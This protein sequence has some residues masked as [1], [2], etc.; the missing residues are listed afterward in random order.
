MADARDRKQDD[1][2]TALVNRVNGL[3]DQVNEALRL[4]STPGP[5]GETG[6]QGP[7]GP[8]GPAGPQGPKGDPGGTTTQPPPTQPPPTQP[9][10][11]GTAKPDLFN[12]DQIRD[13]PGN[14]SAPG[15]ISEVADPLGS[16]QTVFKM[17]VKDSDRVISENPRAQLE[18]PSFVTPNLEFWFRTK[19]LIPNEFPTFSGWMTL[20]SV[21]GPPY[22]GSGPWHIASGDGR[23]IGWE[24]HNWRVPITRGKWMDIMQHGVF[25]ENGFL[26]IFLNGQLSMP[27]TNAALR[28]RTNS[29]G[30]N[31]VRI[32]QYRQA[33]M[34]DV[35]TLYWGPLLCGTTRASVGG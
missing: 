19:L 23:N 3:Q 26:E 35:A 16:G 21:Y 4:S 6:P 2:I 33:G 11:T 13:F 30:N 1:R 18:S 28:N 22:A 20:F 24:D 15:A 31:N 7:P 10:P 32:A 12:G 34:F 5:R 17:T 14:Q 8:M 9:P 25:S 27:K 29:G